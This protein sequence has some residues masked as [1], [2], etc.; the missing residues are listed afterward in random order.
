[1]KDSHRPYSRH[2]GGSD[3]QVRLPRGQAPGPNHPGSRTTHQ[4]PMITLRVNLENRDFWR[5]RT[6]EGFA[7]LLAVWLTG[8]KEALHFRTL[9][10][11]ERAEIELAL[12]APSG[13]ERE[14]GKTLSA[15]SSS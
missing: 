6:G 1:M 9:H 3:E 11:A 5:T 12:F 14:R 8:R 2:R 13:R 10:L 15:F 4:E 7:P